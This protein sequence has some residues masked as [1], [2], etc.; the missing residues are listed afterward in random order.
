MMFINI[1]CGIAVIAAASPMMQTKLGYTPMQAAAIV[2]LI[3]VFN[4]LGRILWSSLSDYIGRAVTY[5]VFFAFQIVAF[6]LLPNLRAELVFLFVLFTVITMYGGGFATLPAFL[7]DL[8]GT[9][10]LGAIHGL[11]LTAWA[12]A[13]LAGPT[14]YDVVMKRTQ[15]LE[16]T[17]MVFSGMFVVALITSIFMFREVKN[18][19]ESAE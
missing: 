5:I 7:G 8:F 19:H 9:K 1:S 6:Y 16:S 11:I 14:I 2:G 10:Q 15:S 12:L 18:A 13:G 3:G 4:G 17:L